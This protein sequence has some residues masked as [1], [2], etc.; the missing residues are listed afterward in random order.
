[1]VDGCPW[2]EDIEGWIVTGQL[3]DQNA[4]ANQQLALRVS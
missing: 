3:V 4:Y 2:D 1:M